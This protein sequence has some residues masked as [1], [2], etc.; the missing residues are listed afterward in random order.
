MR[1]G[2]NGAAGEDSP[3]A[4]LEAAAARSD[5]PLYQVTL[6][7]HQSMTQPGFRWFMVALAGGLSVPLIAAWGTPVGPFLAP[8]LI[9]ALALV[10]AMIRLNQRARRITETLRLWPDLIAVERREPGGRVL[11]WAAN[12]YWVSIDLRDTPA[13]EKYLTLR[14]GGRTIELGAFLTPEERV[15]LADVLRAALRRAMMAGGG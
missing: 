9:A 5:P 15:E 14:G 3:A 11:R 12:P 7:P 1:D 8:F 6:W 10:W 13:L 2:R 4:S